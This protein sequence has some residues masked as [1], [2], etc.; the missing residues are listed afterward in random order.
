MTAPALRPYLWMLTGSVCFSAM[1]LLIRAAADRQACDWQVQGVVRSGIA[2]LFALTAALLTGARLTLFR[3]PMLWLRGLAGSA[4][5]VATFYALARLQGSE[6]LTLTNTFPVWVA[7]IVSVTGG[8]RLT[9]GVWAAVVLAVVGVAVSQGALSGAQLF[10]AA[11]GDDGAAIVVRWPRF[12]SFS[13]PVL[14]ALV[15]AFFTAVAMLGLNRVH[16]VSSLGIVAHFSAV[17]TV[18]CATAYFV[19]PHPVG[20]A[21]L[22]Q[23]LNAALVFGV[24]VSATCG[25]VCLTKAFRSGPATRVSVVSLTQ[26]VFTM[27]VEAVAGWR[28][29]DAW[30]LGGT[31]LVLIPVGWLMTRKKPVSP[32]EPVEPDEVVEQPVAVE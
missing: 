4:S 9:R 29:F 16:G 20:N 23:P 24:G 8:E 17:A 1:V 14:A 22:W 30:T 12:S 6:V 18:T 15:A 25:Q 26:V 32:P 10:G 5:M 31:A 2:F 19:F 11:I 27:L 13:L 7:V 3:P 21:G 28:A